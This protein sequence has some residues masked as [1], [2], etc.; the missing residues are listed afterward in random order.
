MKEN[1]RKSLEDEYEDEEPSNPKD[2]DE[3]LPLEKAELVETATISRDSN[4][5]FF[6]RFPQKIADKLKLGP[7]MRLEFTISV[8]LK[9]EETV[10]TFTCR[11]MRGES[12]NKEED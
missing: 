1:I 10:S 2:L 3:Y 5:Q 12:A 8:L 9:S 6:V 7:K 11:V 4:G